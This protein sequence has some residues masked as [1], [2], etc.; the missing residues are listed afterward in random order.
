MILQE[1]YIAKIL[2]A[3][4]IKVLTMETPTKDTQKSQFFR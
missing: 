1:D 4:K 3:G 2:F